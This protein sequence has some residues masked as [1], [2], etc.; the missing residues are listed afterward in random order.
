MRQVVKSLPLSA[1]AT[2]GNESLKA[3]KLLLG[4]VL[5]CKTTHNARDVDNFRSIY[6]YNMILYL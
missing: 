3:N 6:T 1:A 2:I 4:E 5:P